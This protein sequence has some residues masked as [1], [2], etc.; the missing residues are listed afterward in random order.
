MY[1]S[2]ISGVKNCFYQNLFHLSSPDL[3]C[4]CI[5]IYVLHKGVNAGSDV[6][7]FYLH[8]DWVVKAGHIF[9]QL[10]NHLKSSGSIPADE[11]STG[12]PHRIHFQHVRDIYLCIPHSWTHSDNVTIIPLN[13]IIDQNQ[14]LLYSPCMLYKHRI[15]CGREVQTINIYES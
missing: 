3:H 5:N 8:V 13:F 12:V 10:L 4:S 14:N 1:P 11:T 15:D 6:L 2:R 7:R 9:A